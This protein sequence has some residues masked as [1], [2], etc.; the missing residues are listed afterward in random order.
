MDMGVCLL[1]LLTRCRPRHPTECSREGSTASALAAASI[2]RITEDSE[3][4]IRTTITVSMAA[5]MISKTGLKK[6]GG[7][8]IP[9]IKMPA[10]AGSASAS[11]GASPTGGTTPA[12][13]R[14]TDITVIAVH[15][16]RLIMDNTM[17]IKPDTET[18]EVLPLIPA[19]ANGRRDHRPLSK[20][21]R[22]SP[23]IL[24]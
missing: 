16:I 1:S 17:M 10:P 14:K 6:I 3:V 13:P 5:T 20:A 22:S 8:E 18:A 4:T 15:N 11:R 21:D 19:V 2:I 9:I 12:K 23:E 24:G 7:G